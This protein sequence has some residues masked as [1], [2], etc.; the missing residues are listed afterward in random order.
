MG[1]PKFACSSGKF[2]SKGGM[3][4]S[5]VGEV[6]PLKKSKGVLDGVAEGLLVGRGEAV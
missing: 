3:V 5:G 6:S 4:G 1:V 2:K